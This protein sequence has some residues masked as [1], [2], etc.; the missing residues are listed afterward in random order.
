VVSLSNFHPG[1]WYQILP[2]YTQDGIIISDIFQGSTD[3]AVFENFYQ[4][5]SA[6]LSAIPSTEIGASYG[7]CILSSL[8]EDQTVMFGCR[9]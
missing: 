2:A 7:Q 5:I 8:G 6:A 1:Q 9:G 4:A 3:A